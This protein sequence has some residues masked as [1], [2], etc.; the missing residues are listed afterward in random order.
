MTVTDSREPEADT[1]RLS[2]RAWATL[3]VLCG[4]LVSAVNAANAGA[5]KSPQALLDGFHAALV[6]P[7]IVAAVGVAVTALGTRRRAAVAA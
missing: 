5:G 2:R 6:V 1:G 3:L 7:L 4:A